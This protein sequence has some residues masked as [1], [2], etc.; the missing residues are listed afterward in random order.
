MIVDMKDA[1]LKKMAD[2]LK[3][4]YEAYHKSMM[5]NLEFADLEEQIDYIIG[6][7]YTDEGKLVSRSFVVNAV[8]NILPEYDRKEIAKE[9]ISQLHTQSRLMTDA[10]SFCITVLYPKEVYF[11]NAVNNDNIHYWLINIGVSEC[12]SKAEVLEAAKE[13]ELDIDKVNTVFDCLMS[14]NHTRYW[15]SKMVEIENILIF[16]PEPED[17]EE[18]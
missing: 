5:E 13:Y 4:S 17:S 9:V 14:S 15:P 1:Q 7:F 8:H 11:A 18:W 2:E 16:E 3:K 12:A 6:K 10:E